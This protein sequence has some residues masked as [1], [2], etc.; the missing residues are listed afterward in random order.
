MNYELGVRSEGREMIEV[1]GEMKK[2]KV[3]TLRRLEVEIKV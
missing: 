2:K 1:N 3:E